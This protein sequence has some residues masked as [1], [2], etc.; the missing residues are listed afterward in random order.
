MRTSLTATTAL[1]LCGAVAIPL[2]C[3]I[4]RVSQD[5][6][7]DDFER[8]AYGDWEVVG[9]AFGDGPARGALPKQMPV[10]DY[11]GQ[12]LINSFTGGDA[13]TGTMTSPE[14]V[15]SR[16]YVTFLIGGGAHA[17]KTCVDLLVDGEVVRTATGSES[18]SLEW[19]SWDVGDLAGQAARLRV[20]DAESGGWG[21]ICV[22]QIQ[23]SDSERRG[24]G[25]EIAAYRG[26]P[27]YYREPYRPQFHFTPEIHW[28]N[29]PNGLVYF[30]G[31]YHLFYQHNPFGNR[32]G[33]MSWGHAVS[34]DLVHWQHLPLAL[35]E[36]DGVMIFSG[37]AVVDRENTSGFGTTDDPPLVAIYTGHRS[38]NQ[39]QHIAYSTDRGR[40]WTKYA[41]N[42]VIDVGER[43]F[44]D[45][46]VF[47]HE[48]T[49]R[50]VMVVSLAAKKVLQF[51]GSSDLKSWKH[52]SDFGPAGAPDKPNWECPDLFELPIEGGLGDTFWVLEVDMGSGSV[53]GGSGGEYFVGMFDGTR[54]VNDG[55]PER[56]AWVDYGR[57]FYAPVSFSDIPAA[58]GRRIWIGWLNNWQ[59]SLLPTHP[60]R[61]AQSIPRVL[62]LREV[63]G[64]LRL[65]Q[66]PVRELEKLRV[67]RRRLAGVDV[68]GNDKTLAAAGIEGAQLEIRAVLEPGNAKECGLKVRQGDDEET[69]IGYDVAKGTVF[70]DRTRSGD[71]DFDARFA[72]RHEGPLSLTDGRVELVIYVDTSSVE[73][74]AGDGAV[75]ITDRIFPS[76]DSTGLAL[77]SRGGTARAV[78]ID[79]WELKSAW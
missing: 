68:R 31:E 41:R 34:P 78:T 40:T 47:W 25:I 18:E 54:F 11:I 20:V 59:T 46:K 50:W 33:H 9:E 48:P 56:V 45:P 28:M 30:G 73:V 23:L 36:E 44:R 35:A 19:H 14:F 74:F 10:S 12:R 51:W 67:E 27:R 37:C 6:V 24:T 71:V 60:W 15:L 53:A 77:Y 69:V 52:L 72:G 39:S 16:R 13:A 2:S 76:E 65:I 64:E 22:D 38:D 21:H 3:A 62:S 4:S 61:S 57:D 42:P 17:R 66:R 75:V 29:D 43:D 63:D 8:E 79:V 49:E 5:V 1:A 26:S 7:I 58:D 55:P 70:V 32:W